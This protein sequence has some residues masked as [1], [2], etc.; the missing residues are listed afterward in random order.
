[1]LKRFLLAM[2]LMAAPVYANVT[3][4]PIQSPTQLP[5]S[6]QH[7][8][9]AVAFNSG[10]TVHGFCYTV[11]WGGC[12]GR[13]CQP[14]YVY[15]FYDTNWNEDTS[16]ASSVHC[17]QWVSHEPGLSAWTYDPGYSAANCYKAPFPGSGPQEIVIVGAYEQ[18]ANLESVSTDGVYGLWNVFGTS[19]IGEF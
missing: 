19:W 6:Q 1:M 4:T 9:V 7:A 12:S 3:V 2:T 11:S 16:V 8:C 18:Y 13:G 10:D 14:T 17:G 15:Q 5:K